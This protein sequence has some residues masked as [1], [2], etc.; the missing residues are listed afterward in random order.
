MHSYHSVITPIAS[1]LKKNRIFYQL[2]LRS[3]WNSNTVNYRKRIRRWMFKKSYD[4]SVLDIN[5]VPLKYGEYGSYS[6]S[7]CED[8][9]GALIVKNGTAGLDVECS[10]RIT[11]GIKQKL[12]LKNEEKLG[13]PAD[14]MWVIK[15]AAFKANQKKLNTVFEIE[16]QK[17][18]KI[19]NN[20]WYFETLNTKG[21]S[22]RWKKWAFA[23]ALRSDFP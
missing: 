23:I 1:F 15:E 9:G 14:I 6:I 21:L 19:R 22:L 10:E 11:E 13:V 3:N 18:Q 5:H 2:E 4:E 20:R 16:I 7:H 12:E 8:L 17:F